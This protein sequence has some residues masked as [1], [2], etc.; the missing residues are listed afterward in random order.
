M[1]VLLEL[2]VSIGEIVAGAW[3]TPSRKLWLLG[4]AVGTASVVIATL[5]W[6]R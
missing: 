2:I 3:A 5:V 4:F 1:S 6:G